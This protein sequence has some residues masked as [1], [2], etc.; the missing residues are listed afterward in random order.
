MVRYGHSRHRSSCP[1]SLDF[2]SSFFFFFLFAQ[3]VTLITSCDSRPVIIY[4]MWP[5]E[6]TASCRIFYGFSLYILILEARLAWLLVKTELESSSHSFTFPCLDY[7]FGALTSYFKKNNF[8]LLTLCGQIQ[9]GL[10]YTTLLSFSCWK[11]SLLSSHL[12]T[13]LAP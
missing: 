1:Y 3:L 11:D 8:I 7:L 13:C 10:S 12:F 4:L 9:E 5:K 2:A 6:L